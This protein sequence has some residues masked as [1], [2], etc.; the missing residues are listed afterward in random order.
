M[1][2]VRSV[3][4]VR[5]RVSAARRGGARVGLVPTMGAF[6]E[7]H[8]SL[9][10]AARAACDLVVV[11]LF[12]NPTQFRPGEDLQAYPRDEA[13]D[14]RMAEAA[15]VDVVFA[16]PV[17]E[18]YPDGF[19]TTVH[20]RGV[21]EPLEGH[22]RGVEHFDGVATVVTKLFNMVQ[23][24]AAY[25]GQKDAQQVMVIRRL[26]RDLDLP[27]E[28][29]I[30]PTVREPDG[31]AMSSRNVYLG[32]EDRARAVALSRA[33]ADA[34]AAVREGERDAAAVLH[35]ARRRLAEHGV[36]PQYLE[37]V[38]PETALPVERI[39]GEALVVVAAVVGS[40]RLIDNALLQ[41]D[42]D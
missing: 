2:V 40:A 39:D 15:G 27:V 25:F 23:P 31:L 37:V 12:V 21:S 26:V 3:G 9:M 36:E 1:E 11:S 33:L 17:A 41:P 28:I 22:M 10:R 16:P 35:R 6:H 13:R 32:P 4:E 34:R 42:A 19:A 5:A 18:V 38:S 14:L 29:E 8:L 30:Q 20:V 7:G 24:D